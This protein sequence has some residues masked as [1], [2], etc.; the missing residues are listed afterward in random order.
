MTGGQL[1]KNVYKG[2]GDKSSVQLVFSGEYDYNDSNNLQVD[3]LNEILNIKLIERL[4]EKE[5]GVYAPGVRAYYVKYPN[6]R[7]II[8]VYFACEPAT[9]DKLSPQTMQ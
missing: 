3:A 7:Y 5:S 2:I 1:T 9:V 6:S 4:R 8:T